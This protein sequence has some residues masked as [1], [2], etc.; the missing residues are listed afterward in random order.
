VEPAPNDEDNLTIGWPD[1]DIRRVLEHGHKK[2]DDKKAQAEV[3][4]RGKLRAGSSGCIVDGLVHG[5]CHRIAHLRHVGVDKK[6]TLSR[7]LM[8]QAGEANED[9]WDDVLVEGWDGQVLRHFEA[10]KQLPFGTIEGHPDIILADREG[11]HRFVLELKLLSALYTSI[12]RTFDGQPDEKHLIQSA[13]YM[14]MT[15]L[16]GVLCYTNRTD[17]AVQFDRKRLGGIAKIEPCYRLYYLKIQNGRLFWR[18]EENPMAVET[19]ITIAG[20]REYYRVVAGLRDWDVKTLG[21]RPVSA[22]YDRCDA[23]YCTFSHA[24][25]KWEHNYPTWL[26]EARLAVET[27]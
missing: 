23:K 1:V 16:P 5:E 22:G 4:K 15:G 18:D 12:Q 27:A 10:A 20:I 25:D 11:R 2:I 21:E 19:D 17:F 24:C 3:G 8:F 14:W 6:H 26:H 9:L 13:T 7:K